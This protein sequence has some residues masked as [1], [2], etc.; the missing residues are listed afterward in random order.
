MTT[1]EYT[2]SAEPLQY[3]TPVWEAQVMNTM[4]HHTESIGETTSTSFSFVPDELEEE[5]DGPLTVI[6]VTYCVMLN[7][8]KA[9]VYHKDNATV[10]FHILKLSK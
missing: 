1:L 8:S 2:H 10:A 9:L 5:L 6:K 7:I 4:T 3:V